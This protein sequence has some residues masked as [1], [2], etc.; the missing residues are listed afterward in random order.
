[1]ELAR[2]TQLRMGD[3]GQPALAIDGHP[4]RSE[5]VCASPVDP[6]ALIRLPAGASGQNHRFRGRARLFVA[7]GG[8][9]VRI[10][11]VDAED[12][13]HVQSPMFRGIADVVSLAGALH[14]SPRASSTDD[15]A[16]GKAGGR[17]V[18]R[19]ATDATKE[20]A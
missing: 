3:A 4:A 19:S 13:R 7:E 2:D 8:L 9:E 5:I 18:P 11:D 6:R 17:R 16:P 12:E 20:L 14:R 10:A 15:I 1:C